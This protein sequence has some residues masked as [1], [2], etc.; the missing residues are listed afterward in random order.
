MDFLVKIRMEFHLF[1]KLGG[2]R[3]EGDI[4]LSPEVAQSITEYIIALLHLT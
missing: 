4:R 1:K 3:R 2:G